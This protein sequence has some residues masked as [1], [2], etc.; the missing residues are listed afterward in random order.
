MNSGYWR[1]GENLERLAHLT[2]FPEQNPNPVVELDG[3]GLLYANPA[4]LASFPDLPDTGEDHPLLS[5]CRSVASGL[6]DSGPVSGTGEL[7]FGE[8]CYGL[9]VHLVPGN[10]GVRAYVSDVTERQETWR[11]L[12]ES[13]R[14]F[15]QLFD[16]VSEAVFL[17]DTEGR[18]VDC[19]AEARLSLGY[20]REELLS[21]TIEDIATDVL[22]EEER[23]RQADT[24]WRKALRVGPGLQSS[25]HKNEH[26]R[27]DGTTF[28][29]EV[30]IG[31]VDYGE[32]RLLLASARDISGRRHL[33]EEL[34]YR[35]HHDPLTNLP[36]RALLDAR[37]K[38]AL[39]RSRRRDS[40]LTRLTHL[41][42][43]FLR[44]GGLDQG[45]ERF[46]Y[47]A[48][49]RILT[50]VARRVRGCLGPEDTVGRVSGDDLAVLSESAADREQAERT[51]QE[52]LEDL[53][54]PLT[55]EEGEIQVEVTS[56][57]VLIPFESAPE[58]PDPLHEAYECM[59]RARLRGDLYELA[60]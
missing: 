32:R 36:N 12:A 9:D 1:G 40:H 7:E 45:R 2:A 28:P 56:G 5:R 17:H 60:P 55:L 30:G 3:R 37:L 57:V 47:R 26:R 51:I 22:S 13:E 42:V 14:R 18:I 41:T 23:H 31:A 48:G 52:V 24:P 38:N 8:A 11:L 44:V 15:Q 35:T 19:N 54:K 50:E 39:A 10:D 4:A 53:Q 20:T 27:K 34:A 58:A 16:S 33:E 6:R 43:M 25:F 49:D 46:G 21:L 59:C 29:V